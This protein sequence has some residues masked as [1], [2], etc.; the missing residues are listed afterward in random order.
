MLF[1]YA[2]TALNAMQR[3]IFIHT[4][5]IRAYCQLY[6]CD[7]NL[8]SWEKTYFWT[9]SFGQFAYFILI[10]ELM[11]VEANYRFPKQSVPSK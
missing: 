5:A 6:Y 9:L 7:S 4:I 10:L 2:Q 8:N 3:S 1:G 11:E